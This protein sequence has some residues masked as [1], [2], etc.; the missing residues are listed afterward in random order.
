[1]KGKSFYWSIFS[2]IFS[3]VG[4]FTQVIAIGTGKNMVSIYILAFIYITPLLIDAIED[5]AKVEACNYQQYRLDRIALVTGV[6]YFLLILI[7]FVLHSSY[8]NFQLSG[9]WEKIIKCILIASP[10]VFIVRAFYAFSIKW[11]QNT[12]VAKAYYQDKGVDYQG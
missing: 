6:G 11:S 4:F 2:L 5:V 3:V 7:L 1:M 10:S 8:D 12:N 9:C